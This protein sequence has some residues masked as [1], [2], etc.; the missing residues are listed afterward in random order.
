MGAI[1][2]FIWGF[3]GGFAAELFVLLPSRQSSPIPAWLKWWFF[4]VVTLLRILAGGVLVIA[5]LRS[6][7]L[8][9][10]ILAINV[11]ASAP[12]II[13]SLANQVP[14]IDPGTTRQ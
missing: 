12:L 14:P 10:P 5:Y 8:I 4:W 2:G 9:T 6:H 3:F 13:G 11:G 7:M 1:E